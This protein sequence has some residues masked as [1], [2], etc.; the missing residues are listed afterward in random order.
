MANKKHLAILQQGVE[1]WNNWRQQNP[2]IKP[3]LRNINLSKKKLTGINFAN[4]DL[5]GVNFNNATL[6]KADFSHAQ[7]GL[8]YELFWFVS[9]TIT[10]FGI[11]F[12]R[13]DLINV[14]LIYFIALFYSILGCTFTFLVNKPFL[15]Q[16]EKLVSKSESN[17]WKYNRN[18][19]YILE[20]NELLPNCLTNIIH[21]IYWSFLNFIP[22]FYFLAWLEPKLRLF[23][24]NDNITL[25]IFCCTLIAIFYISLSGFGLNI[26]YL[27]RKIFFF[28]IPITRFINANLTDANFSCAYVAHVDFIKANIKRTNWNKARGIRQISINIEEPYILKPLILNLILHRQAKKQDL[29]K[30]NLSGLNLSKTDFEKSKLISTDLSKSNLSFANFS[31]ANLTKAQLSGADLTGATLTG[32]CI[33]D[34]KINSQTNLTNVVCDYIYLKQSFKER[35]PHSGK[36]KPGE[37]TKRYQKILE[38]VDLYFD[39]GIDWKIFLQSFNKLKDEDKLRIKSGKYQLPIVQAIEN[40]NDRSFLIKVGVSPD[41]NK[42]EWEKSFRNSYNLLLDAKEQTINILSTELE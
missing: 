11:W 39:D 29:E 28:L 1:V 26:D 20:N 36:F 25:L 42:E 34:W 5:R 40:K 7:L 23:A 31:N 8:N 10:V 30:I 15:P 22:L 21:L 18:S 16:H 9:L 27:L 12:F 3:N 19:T 24:D 32:A 37:F 33:E 2:Q 38:T 35:R 13:I 17:L 41:T 4:T 6:I 14:C